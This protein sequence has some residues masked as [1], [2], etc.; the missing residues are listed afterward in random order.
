[1]SKE[2]LGQAGAL[3]ISAGLAYAGIN[4]FIPHQGVTDIKD[5]PQYE[6]ESRQCATRFLQLCEQ[7]KVV[8]TN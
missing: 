6:E 8:T 5:H 3:L 2:K 4:D 7:N 1:M